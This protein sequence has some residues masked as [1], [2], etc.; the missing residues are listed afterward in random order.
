MTDS[1][2]IPVARL[3]GR[4]HPNDLSVQQ[5]LGERAADW[6]RAAGATTAIA[7]ASHPE[8]VVPS[9]GQHQAATCRMGTEPGTSVTD[10]CGRVWGI[11]TCE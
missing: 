5:L 1:L 4:L 9:S 6:L 11:R 7:Y 8:N 2:G 10:P 3:S